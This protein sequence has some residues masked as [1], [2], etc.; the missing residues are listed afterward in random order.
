M[1]Y[2]PYSQIVQK[3]VKQTGNNVNRS[4]W[5]KGMSI[6]CTML[7]LP[8]KLK[9]FLNIKIKKK[10]SLIML[11]S[12]RSIT[13]MYSGHFPADGYL[14]CSSV[15]FLLSTVLLRTFSW[16]SGVFGKFFLG[17]Y[18]REELLNY[19]VYENV[20]LYKKRKNASPLYQF[21]ESTIITAFVDL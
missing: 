11:H 7:I 13:P 8:N 19:N 2:G 6:P 16:S 14:S 10:D 20:R 9:L 3:I 21:N 5:I 12:C 1:T 15:C 18:P 4:I 17:I